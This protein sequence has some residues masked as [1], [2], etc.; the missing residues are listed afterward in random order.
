MDDVISSIS[1]LESMITLSV[2]SSASM[3]S[4]GTRPIS[5]SPTAPSSVSC[6]SP[7]DARMRPSISPSTTNDSSS[8]WKG[9]SSS[10]EL[11]P[12]PP[13]PGTWYCVLRLLLDAPPPDCP[14]AALP[15]EPGRAPCELLPGAHDGVCDLLGV[16]GSLPAA[17]G[18]LISPSAASTR[19]PR[20]ASSTSSLLKP[21]M[22]AATSAG[23]AWGGKAS[24][25]ALAAAARCGREELAATCPL[26]LGAGRGSR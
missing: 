23:E 11:L 1:L 21:S 17:G 26:V 10:N 14:A 4:A 16:R 19:S 25:A 22:A 3:S 12:S 15:A 7:M 24:N 9:S 5:S 6:S 20:P 18:R 13:P 2:S 8:T